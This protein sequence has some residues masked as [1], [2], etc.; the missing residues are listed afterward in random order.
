MLVSILGIHIQGFCSIVAVN[1][2]TEIPLSLDFFLSLRNVQ[3]DSVLIKSMSDRSVCFRNICLS[4]KVL[5]TGKEEGASATDALPGRWPQALL[6]TFA[7]F[8]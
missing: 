6:Y 1:L 2:S 3:A 5:F 4:P 7:H 8:P